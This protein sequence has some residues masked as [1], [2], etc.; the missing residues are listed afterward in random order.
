VPGMSP[1]GM[2][3]TVVCRYGVLS[4][5]QS[6]C[7][8]S[9]YHRAKGM[10]SVGEDQFASLTEITEDCCICVLHFLLIVLATESL[11]HLLQIDSDCNRRIPQTT[12]SYGSRKVTALEVRRCRTRPRLKWAGSVC[13]FSGNLESHNHR[14][15]L[16]LRATL[17][18]PRCGIISCGCP[19]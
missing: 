3:S 5:S 7:F 16:G 6:E 18:G 15:V 14:G 17:L 11:I 4:S 1:S 19:N 9:W 10:T 12:K 2:P 8:P 13:H